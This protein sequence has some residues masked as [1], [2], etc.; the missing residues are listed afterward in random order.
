M[1][2]MGRKT[3]DS[4]S[5]RRGG[6]PGAALPL[7][8][9]SLITWERE[10]VRAA[11]ITLGEGAVELVGVAAA[12]VHGIGPTSHPDLDRWFAGC[13]RAL[14]QAEDMT[15]N[16]G[17]HKIVPD[18]VTMSIPA[19]V[20]RSLPVIVAR[21]H[22]EAK[23]G[24]PQPLTVTAVELQ[25]LLQ[26]GYRRAQDVLGLAPPR[27]GGG[28]RGA[29][30]DI[31]CGAL[32]EIVLDGQSV[33]APVGLQGT[34]LELRLCF[35]LAPLEWIRA[36]EIVAERLELNL[37]RLVPQ[38]V[39]L[40]A[41]LVD[42]A[43]LLIT[44]D[45]Q[46]TTVSMVQHGHVAWSGLVGIGERHLV[47]ATA[48]VLELSGHQADALMRAYRARQLREDIELQVAQAF[49]VE[50]RRWLMGVSDCIKTLA[51]SGPLTHRVHFQD[52]TRRLPEAMPS[53]G[54]P[55]WEQSLPFA[56]CPEVLEVNTHTVG[57]VLDCTSQAGGPAHLPLRALAYHVGQY[58]AAGSVLDRALAEAIRWRHSGGVRPR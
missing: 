27:R 39:A 49:W 52:A 6:G 45:E 46:H 30:E 13:D 22:P 43:A 51:P 16:T 23:R 15:L 10:H 28:G 1:G 8:Y 37:V 53:L 33:T 18:Y 5:G 54:T 20:T 12:P 34:A 41:P 21:Q 24:G 35:F 25:E 32:A 58:H 50:L 9:H 3:T 36:L 38:Q 56:R 31:I 47:T 17:T 40:A 26:R 14:T 57:E 29:A 42:P 19:E 48:A 44:L 11:V 55:F 7:A 2:V 4:G